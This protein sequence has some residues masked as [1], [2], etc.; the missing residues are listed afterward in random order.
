MDDQRHLHSLPNTRP[1]PPYVF[2]QPATTAAMSPQTL[3]LPNGNPASSL[4]QDLGL[5]GMRS[6]RVQPRHARMASMP[7]LHATN[8]DGEVADTAATTLKMSSSPSNVRTP[9]S[10]YQRRRENVARAFASF[11]EDKIQ[12]ASTEPT[13]G[14][15]AALS[16][17]RSGGSP[18]RTP[19]ISGRIPATDPRVLD[20][21]RAPDAHVPTSYYRHTGTTTPPSAPPK[22]PTTPKSHNP[23]FSYG[24]YLNMS[25][26]PQPRRSPHPA[27]AWP[28]R[29]LYQTR[30]NHPAS[31]PSH[32]RHVRHRSDGDAYRHTRPLWAQS[33]GDAT[34]Q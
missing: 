28:R 7:V 22:L 10:D 19:P 29:S 14:P 11:R 26:S 25:P 17:E 15:P 23:N 16:H 1:R 3:R 2:P 4:A 18:P 33:I 8:R 13:L 32:T 9:E 5:G 34:H 12:S 20:G 30:R 24:E 27:S 21:R 6:A 31:V